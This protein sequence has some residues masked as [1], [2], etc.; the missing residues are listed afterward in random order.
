MGGAAAVL[1]AMGR[2]PVP[3]LMQEHMLAQHVAQPSESGMCSEP[4]VAAG[5][6]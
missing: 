1:D 4:S 6:A 2:L 3:P 5:S